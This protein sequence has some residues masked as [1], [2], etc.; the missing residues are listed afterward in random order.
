MRII[1]ETGEPLGDALGLVREAA[2]IA[3]IERDQIDDFIAELT[4]GRDSQP[5]SSMS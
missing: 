1:G 3:G 2:R 5:V 4:E